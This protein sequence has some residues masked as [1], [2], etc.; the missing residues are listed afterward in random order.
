VDVIGHQASAATVEQ[1]DVDGDQVGTPGAWWSRPR[2]QPATRARS[3]V[4]PWTKTRTRIPRRSAP[5]GASRRCCASCAPPRPRRRGH[6]AR[7]TRRD[8][9]PS[10]GRSPPRPPLASG[11]GTVGSGCSRRHLIG[12]HV[13][14]N[15]RVTPVHPA[16][17]PSLRLFVA[18]HLTYARARGVPCR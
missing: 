10:E 16:W 9:D 18:Q 8:S 15:R 2:R 13:H 14:R 11:R 3:G 7:Q 1:A 17:R 4:P 5:R 12:E 6:V